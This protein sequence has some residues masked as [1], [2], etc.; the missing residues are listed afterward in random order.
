M[1]ASTPAWCHTLGDSESVLLSCSNSPSRLSRSRCRV[2]VV[3]HNP[4]LVT[5]RMMSAFTPEAVHTHTQHNLQ[6]HSHTW[7][8]YWC[9]HTWPSVGAHTLLRVVRA[10]LH[11]CDVRIRHCGPD[12]LRHGAILLAADKAVVR[13]PTDAA[14]R[15]HRNDVSRL[16][17]LHSVLHC[18]CHSLGRPTLCV[19]TETRH[20]DPVCRAR[21]DAVSLRRHR[22]A[23]CP[24]TAKGCDRAAV[25]PAHD[26]VVSAR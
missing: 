15:R 20:L 5:Y 17:H 9:S 24:L 14:L 21:A 4:L 2:P 22:A 6:Q 12:A 18:H 26:G 7:Q 16:F 8:Q 13:V 1:S 23:L 19:T 3:T 25:R 10:D 11:R